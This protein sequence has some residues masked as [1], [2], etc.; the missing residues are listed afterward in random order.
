MKFTKMMAAVA[1][2]NY[3]IAASEALR[4]SNG[5]SR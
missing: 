4:F 3:P 5:R 1:E 2:G